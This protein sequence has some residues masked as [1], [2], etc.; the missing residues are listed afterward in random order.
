MPVIGWKYDFDD[1][2]EEWIA[3]KSERIWVEYLFSLLK[4][5]G[6]SGRDAASTLNKNIFWLW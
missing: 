6:K 3:R 2:L 1:H 5:A 4:T